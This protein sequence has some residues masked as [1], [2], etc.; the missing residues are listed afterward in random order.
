MQV[1]KC[2]T[3]EV[4]APIVARLF[5]PFKVVNFDASVEVY[6]VWGANTNCGKTFCAF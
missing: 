5:V 2:I 3:F 1:W 4:P 6:N